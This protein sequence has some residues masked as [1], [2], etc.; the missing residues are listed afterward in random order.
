MVDYKHMLWDNLGE[1]ALEVLFG[2]QRMHSTSILHNCIYFANPMKMCYMVCVKNNF[3][4]A[5]CE[6][7]SLFVKA[8]WVCQTTGRCNLMMIDGE[9]DEEDVEDDE[10]E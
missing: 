1:Q 5:L 4:R 6:A 9:D 10:E 8:V 2:A 7:E 3:L